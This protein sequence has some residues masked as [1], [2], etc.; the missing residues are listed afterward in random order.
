MRFQILLDKFDIP[1]QLDIATAAIVE[2]PIK[3][4]VRKAAIDFDELLAKQS[5]SFEMASSEYLRRYRRPPPPGF[6]IWYDYATR[7]DSPIIDEFDIINETLAPFWSL[8]GAEVKRSLEKVHG[9]SISH[10]QPSNHHGQ[11]GCESLGG[12][13]IDSLRGAGVLAHLPETDILINEM[14][15]PRALTGGDEDFDGPLDWT[16]LS[17]QSIWD[18]ITAG[19]HNKGAS[20]AMR[21]PSEMH[22]S[23]TAGLKLCTSKSHALDLCRHPEYHKMHGLWRS[24][25]SFSA[26][27]SKVPILSPAVLSTMGDIPVPAAAYLNPE[28]SYH[29]PEDVPW[30]NKTAA[31]YWAGKTTGSFQE[32]AHHPWKQGHRQRFVN[33]ANGLEPRIYTYLSRSTVSEPWQKHTSSMLDQSLYAVHFTD[34]VQYANQATNDAIRQYFQIH[35]EEPREEA[36]K[37]TLTFDLDGNGHSGRFYRLLNS[38]SLP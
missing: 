12:E 1:A 38:R 27:H 37:Y 4:L 10:C 21:P 14:D 35:D 25:T 17:H 7:H 18:E 30:E 29:E 6:E 3:T 5:T 23:G 19:C 36:F 31:L 16:D 33:L 8:S 9:P 24:P 28:F 26:I 32:A 22:D 20:N 2:H 13:V 34:V 15:E 11:A